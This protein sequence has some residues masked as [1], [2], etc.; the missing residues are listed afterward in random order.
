MP[1]QLYPNQRM[2]MLDNTQ[3]RFNLRY[4]GQFD[5]GTLEARAYH[6][7]VDH[8]MDFGADKRFWYGSKSGT[9]AP[10]S[11]IRFMG[12]P[13][14][15]CASGMPMYTE[16]KTTGFN[17]KADVQL[18]QQDL[19][20]VGGQFQSYR[21]DDWWP[22][23]GGG[24][25]PGTFDNINDGK[26]DRKALFG[27]WE[28]RIN[29]QWMSLLGV[30]YERVESDAG[31]VQGY[32]TT[33]GAPG[34]QIA[35]AA[36][37]NAQ[38]HERND[39]NWDITALARYTANANSDIEFGFA[40]KVRSPNLYERY[41]WSTWA[42]TAVMNNFVGDGNGY[43]GNLDL[44]P[45]KAHTLSA[46]FDWHAADRNWELKATPFYTEVDDYID[47][48]R[49]TTGSACTA[50]NSSTTNQFVVLQ[51]ANQSARLYGLDLSGYMPLADNS[52]G[53]FRLKG[54]LNYTH[55]KNKDTGDDL[56]NIMP[57]N[58]KATLTHKLGGWEN[59]LE[60][61]MVSSKNDTSD[62]RNE[63]KTPGYGL[64]N[65][66]TSYSWQQ[67]R[68]DLGVENLFDKLYGLPLGGAY[69]GQGTTMGINSIPWGVAVPGMG[70]SIYA[71]F[72]LK[73]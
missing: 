51:Y 47:A 19:L 46:T 4:L 64:T 67:V 58:A 24:M 54:L 73:F 55:G 30:R 44:E 45:E 13:A 29:P 59:A 68:L 8:F 71:G 49:C 69:S 61:V 37:F 48:V 21:L 2:D 18:S 31:N 38:N 66:R 43:I 23:S 17:L 53:Q 70:R 72:N 52:L 65:L 39:N 10:C 60:L 11:P 50:N 28:S 26:R 33:T 15:T 25:G 56:Y 22:A 34:N 7:S 1:E 32:R 6:E 57:L 62:V 14:G 35:D 41:T 27:E 9:G 12:D 3:K 36:A 40:R 5:W 42:M 20:R 63:V 16:S